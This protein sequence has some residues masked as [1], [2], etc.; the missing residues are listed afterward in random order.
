MNILIVKLSSLGDVVQTMPVVADMLAIHPDVQIDWVVEEAFAPLLE[1]LVGDN[2]LNRVIPCGLRRWRKAGVLGWFSPAIRAERAAF[3]AAIQAVT[4]D[5]VIDCQ[6]LTKSALVARIAKLSKGGLRGSFANKSDACGYEWPVKFLLKN[7]QLM[8][9]RIHAI[10]RTRLLVAKMLGYESRTDVWQAPPAV[11]F[12]SLPKIDTNTAGK[13][14]M[15]THGTTRADNEWSFRSWLLLAGQLVASGYEIALPEASDYE[16]SFCDRLKE[17]LIA[18][19][20]DARISILPRMNLSQLLDEMST[21][22]CV[23][24]VD[25]GLS[26]MAVALGLP[27]VQ[28]FSQDRAWRAGPLPLSAGGVAHQVAIGGTFTPTVE[29]V[30]GD[31]HTVFMT[32]IARPH[33]IVGY[34]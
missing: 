34:S 23:I 7:N 12:T 25:S 29:Q 19:A 27:H 15:F 21:C 33:P 11:A 26:H 31:C 18:L 22:T 5:A 32:D 14:M 16:R 6:G 8:P 10:A 30:L 17:R 3:K 24:G 2:G 13:K 28:I 4:Y 1:R 9:K 20:P